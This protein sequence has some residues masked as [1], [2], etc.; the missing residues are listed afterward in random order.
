[1][2]LRV[3]GD[4]IRLR[5]TKSEVKKIGQGESVFEETHFPDGSSFSYRLIPSEKS[6]EIGAQFQASEL[7]IFVPM[8]LAIDW[9][10][11]ETIELQI[12][13]SLSGKPA[14][15]LHVLIEKDF[16]CLKPR[17]HQHEDE[18]DMFENPNSAKGTCG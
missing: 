17:A 4:S 13:Q 16:F 14:S 5:L 11:G 6:L 1:M 12:H 10:K 3:K 18:S 2:K 9:A 15:K 8:A 7:Q